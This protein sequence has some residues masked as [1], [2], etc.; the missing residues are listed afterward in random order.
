MWKSSK[1][2]RVNTYAKHYISFGHSRVIIFRKRR[3]MF[4]SHEHEF[5]TGPRCI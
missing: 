4:G 5:E 1:G 2:S 3:G